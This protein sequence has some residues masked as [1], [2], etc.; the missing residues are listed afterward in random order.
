[1]DGPMMVMLEISAS[2]SALHYA[3]VRMPATPKNMTTPTKGMNGKTFKRRSK[4][5]LKSA[6]PSRI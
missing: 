1:M 6:P 3:W 2:L 4:N 5:T